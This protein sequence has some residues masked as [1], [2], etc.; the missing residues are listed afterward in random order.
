MNPGYLWARA[1][2]LLALTGCA[3]Q[4]THDNVGQDTRAEGRANVQARITPSWEPA[5]TPGA[6][7]PSRCRN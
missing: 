1:A 5:I 4:A 7:T 2:L 3:G 6:N